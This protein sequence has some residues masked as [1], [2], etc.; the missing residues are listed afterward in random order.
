[1]I[2]LKF[3]LDRKSFEVIYTALIRPI[4]EYGDVI[5]DNCAQYEKNEMK[6][7]PIRGSKNSNRYHKINIY[8]HSLQRNW[9]GYTRKT[10][11]ESQTYTIL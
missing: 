5:W 1:M 11:K 9:V 6:K 2:K 10:K 4:L 7:N 8:Q 3:I